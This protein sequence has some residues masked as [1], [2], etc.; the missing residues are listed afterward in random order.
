MCGRAGRGLVRAVCAARGWALTGVG[1]P[2]P[3][4][5]PEQA[6]AV[7]A[8]VAARGAFQPLLLEGVTGSGKTEVY[9]EAIRACLARGQQAL[10]LVPEIGLTPQDLQRF[11]RRLGVPVL[12]FHSGLSDGERA[13]AWLRLAR[14]QAK[15]LVG[16]RSAVFT[17]LP[18]AGLIVI[19]DRKSTRLNSSH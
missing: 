7:A 3:A 4:L 12:A 8:V 18:A 14:N 1:E 19:E 9:L 11:R 5:L 6:Q 16:T 10:V 13:S 17:P 2:G 15:V